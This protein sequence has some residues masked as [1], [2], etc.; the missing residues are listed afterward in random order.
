MT[1]DLL[2]KEAD[3]SKCKESLKT[4]ENSI[5]NLKKQLE[6]NNRNLENEQ[7]ILKSMQVNEISIVV[8]YYF[9][10]LKCSFIA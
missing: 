9:P 1:C 6:E 3:H 10:G 8:F 4:S 5:N 2:P 7:I